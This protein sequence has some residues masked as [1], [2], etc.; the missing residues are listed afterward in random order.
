MKKVFVVNEKFTVLQLLYR[1][2]ISKGCEVRAFSTSQ[3]LSAA[4]AESLPDIIV[5]DADLAYE[6][7]SR[8]YTH[9][10]N[11]FCGQVLMILF[12]A[13]PG[14]LKNRKK[15]AAISDLLPQGFT[16]Y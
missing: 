6:D 3:H 15:E 9:L 13:L 11:K 8:L 10:K 14:N 5:I 4:L 12:S 1:W 16:V 7:G 2:F